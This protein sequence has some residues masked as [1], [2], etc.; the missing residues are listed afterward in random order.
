MQPE[1]THLHVASSYSLRY[2]TATPRALAAR[3]AD[4]GMPALA[5]TDHGNLYGAVEFLREAKAA[6]VFPVEPDIDGILAA[7]AYRE[8]TVVHEIPLAE[9]AAYAHSQPAE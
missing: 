6:E 9:S 4:L 7:V 5:L 3:A 2:G 8:V 1:F